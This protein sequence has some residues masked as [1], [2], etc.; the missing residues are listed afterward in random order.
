MTMTP[1]KTSQKRRHRFGALRFQPRDRSGVS[2]GINLAPMIDVTFLLLIFFLVTTTFERAEGLLTSRMPDQGEGPRVA[3]PID[4]IVVRLIPA[5]PV[6]QKVA[7]HIDNVA[8]MAIGSF[9]ELKDALVTLH[10]E[11]GVDIDTPVVI[12]A[13]D[14]VLWDHVVAS[15]NAAIRARCHHV[16]FGE[17]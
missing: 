12:I 3:L 6:G 8:S 7:I 15:W 17:P 11:P 13:D 2:I 16:A 14:D 9:E 4:P 5:D 1:T 10:D